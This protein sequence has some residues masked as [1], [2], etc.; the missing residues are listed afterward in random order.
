MIKKQGNHI[1]NVIIGSYGNRNDNDNDD[2]NV[3]Q[4]YLYWAHGLI[5]IPLSLSL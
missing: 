3:G 2:D 1:L 5:L 4:S